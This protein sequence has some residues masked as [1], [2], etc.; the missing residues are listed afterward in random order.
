MK[1]R[2]FLIASAGV[3]TAWPLLGRGAI[4]CPPPQVTV[5]GAT[6]STACSAIT[7]QA[8]WVARSTGSG[9]VWAHNFDSASEVNQFRET[10]GYGIDPTGTGSGNVSTVQWQPGGFAG[11]G[12]LR[13]S[14]PTGG[15]SNGQWS[16][17]MSAINAGQ[18]GTAGG[19]GNGKTTNDP[20]AGGAV[21]LHTWDSSQRS[22]AYNWRKGYYANPAVQAKYPGWPLATN[23]GVYD[24]T[25]FYLQFRVRISASRWHTGNPPGKLLFIDVTDQESDL[26]E[27]V[28]RSV[29]NPDGI[30]GASWQGTN[31]LLM[32]TSRGSYANSI[33]DGNQ[34]SN[35]NGAIEPGG[36][37]ASS[38]TYT[39]AH[40]TGACWNYPSGDWATLLLHFVPGQDNSNYTGTPPSGAV[41]GWP[42]HDTTIEVWKCDPGET[43]YTKIF[44]K[45]NLAWFYYT[46]GQTSAPNGP[47]G[48]FH[49]PAFNEIGPSGYMNGV[50][51]AL[52]WTQDFTQIIFSHQF[53]PA[54]LA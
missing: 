38:C 7:Q 49:P 12:F 50:A 24:G 46:D 3:G 1:R 43:A 53:I 13:I 34:D 37:Y 14:I 26:Q 31:P 10:G 41:S 36:P 48:M 54:P 51:A 32:Y 21:S 15:T 22:M 44:E 9:V 4:P 35:Y 17:P 42:Y 40:N 23:T 52:G 20:A 33:I 39:N 19:A 47:N 30:I 29:N 45:F 5:G 11:G 18:P 27:L 2:D 16:R 8:D 28:F 6:V 25:E